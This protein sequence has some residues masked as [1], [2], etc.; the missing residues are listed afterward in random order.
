MRRKYQ[1]TR[2]KLVD[3]ITTNDRDKEQA[4]QN[5]MDTDY[6]MKL[7]KKVHHQELD[8][9]EP[10]ISSF[11][12]PSVQQKQGEMIYFGEMTLALRLAASR[13]L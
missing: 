5:L 9:R 3:W 11:Y 8:L 6:T 10:Q 1:E 12:K 7:H 4:E 2:T 13:F